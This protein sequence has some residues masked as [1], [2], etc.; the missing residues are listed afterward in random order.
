M[1]NSA[2]IIELTDDLSVKLGDLIANASDKEIYSLLN[3]GNIGVYNFY[4]SS[5]SVE[6]TRGNA[7]Y[8]DSDDEQPLY[9]GNIFSH[10][11]FDGIIGDCRNTIDEWHKLVQNWLDDKQIVIPLDDW[12]AD[13]IENDD[14]IELVEKL[15]SN[16]YIVEAVR[17]DLIEHLE[18]IEFR[19]EM[20]DQVDVWLEQLDLMQES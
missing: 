14:A 12:V 13:A 5:M 11:I 18:S 7:D 16:P 19:Q 2:L 3:A 6:F 20:S 1:R 9:F 8:L 17:D 15:F 10:F 4:E